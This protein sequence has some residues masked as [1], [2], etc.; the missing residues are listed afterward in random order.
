MFLDAD[1]KQVWFYEHIGFEKTWESREVGNSL[2]YGM[3]YR[4]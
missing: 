4:K 1:E 2:A 3:I